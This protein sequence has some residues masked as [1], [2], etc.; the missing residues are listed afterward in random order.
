MKGYGYSLKIESR[1][2]GVS[3]NIADLFHIKIKIR[4]YQE[5]REE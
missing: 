2:Q 5:V 3:D 1:L 4:G